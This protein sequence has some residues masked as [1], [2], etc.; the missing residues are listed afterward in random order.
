[1]FIIDVFFVST[2]TGIN[3]KS[4][5]KKNDTLSPKHSVN[6]GKKQTLRMRRLL[7]L[8]KGY[9]CFHIDSCISFYYNIYFHPISVVSTCMMQ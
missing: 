3:E 5:S 4:T 8:V 9:R 6:R 1:M 2:L 7:R